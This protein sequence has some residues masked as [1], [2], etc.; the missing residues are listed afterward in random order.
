MCAYIGVVP[1]LL[2]VGSYRREMRVNREYLGVNESVVKL[3]IGSWHMR[4]IPNDFGE[5][6]MKINQA[7]WT[8]WKEI[9]WNWVRHTWN[10]VKLFALI[11]HY[12]F[13]S[14]R[15]QPRNSENSKRKYRE[16]EKLRFQW[17]INTV[18]DE[19]SPNCSSKITANYTLKVGAHGAIDI[20]Y[21]KCSIFLH[22][23]FSIWLNIWPI[24]IHVYWSL[25]SVRWR[26][27][28]RRA[29][30]SIFPN[31]WLYFV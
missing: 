1:I 9:T 18:D 28:V 19:L 4:N 24:I 3:K 17:S 29:E 21:M 15:Q 14:V 11:P 7:N 22:N 6:F 10:W 26:W 16:R 31:F 5:V 2:C 12:S 30:N 20:N 27:W 8:D 13:T 23:L 25:H